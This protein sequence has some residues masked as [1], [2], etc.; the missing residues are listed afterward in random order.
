MD[1]CLPATWLGMGLPPDLAPTLTEEERY[2]LSQ[3]TEQL[4]RQRVSSAQCEQRLSRLIHPLDSIYAHVGGNRHEH[5]LA[6]KTLIAEM[7][8]RQTPWWTWSE[9]QWHQVLGASRSEFSQRYHIPERR[10]PRGRL[11]LLICA[12]LTGNFSAF[13]HVGYLSQVALAKRVFGEAVFR[14]ALRTVATEMRQMGLGKALVKQG[15]PQFLAYVLLL[16]HSPNLRDITTSLL[17]QARY[18][19]APTYRRVCAVLSRTLCRL[20]ILA[21]PLTRSA[22]AGSY[23]CSGVN[24]TASPEWVSWCD[25]WRAT[26]TEA[27]QTRTNKYMVLVKTG[28][29]LAH[30][31]PE[32]TRPEQWTRELALEWVATVDR[33]VV[34][35]WTHPATLIPSHLKGKPIMPNTKATLLAAVRSFFLAC[36]QWEWIPTRFDPRRT[37]I[38]PRSVR[39]LRGP[40]PRVIADEVWAKLMGAGLTLT[41]ADLP[42]HNQYFRFKEAVEEDPTAAGSLSQ[43]WYPFELVRALTLTWLFGGLRAN[44]IKRLRLGCIRW[45]APQRSSAANSP[46][47]QRVPSEPVRQDQ[48]CLLEVPVHKMGKAFV[49][50]VDRL[51]GE[52]IDT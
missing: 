11:L 21:Q 3:L 28:R 34:G 31:H 12:Y 52:A 23:R 32:V 38:T 42:L 39:I 6:L 40:N 25:R 36:Q 7:N 5:R 48:V 10:G 1:A 27:P 24:D 41:A 4:I 44:E 30:Q 19:I 43:L 35:E 29:W 20:G 17:E 26:S 33:M 45:Q 8:Q 22:W 49:K 46:D 9:N 50:P 2:G 16:A 13:H 51:V 47:K 14:T 15:M 37:I 18:Q